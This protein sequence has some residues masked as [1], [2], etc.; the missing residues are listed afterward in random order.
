MFKENR[1]PE[2]GHG[3][4]VSGWTKNF[5]NARPLSG[6]QAVKMRLLPE[7]PLIKRHLKS[8][9]LDAGC[10]AGEWVQFLHMRGYIAI[11]LDYSEQL[12]EMNRRRYPANEWLVGDIRNVAMPDST[13]GG[14][15]SW[16]VI[17]HDEAGPGAALREFYRL[18][19]P[20]ACCIVTVPVDTERQKTVGLR[21]NEANAGEFFQYYFTPDELAARLREVGFD[22]VHSGLLP[23]KSIGLA[24]PNLYFRYIGTRLFILARLVT[25]FSRVKDTAGM[26]ICI[27]RKPD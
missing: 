5:R 8:P 21:G 1:Q 22:I 15:I 11:G 25:L 3:N 6:L 13:L 18:L 4:S 27:G 19:K 24:A 14:I 2:R 9:I 23:R 16:G 17:E 20:G 7:L 26:T 10:G 12:I